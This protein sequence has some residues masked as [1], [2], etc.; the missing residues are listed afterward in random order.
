MRPREI[1]R[2][3]ALEDLIQIRIWGDKPGGIE[4]VEDHVDEFL[5]SLG[6]RPSLLPRVARLAE[7][8]ESE[9][10]LVGYLLRRVPEPFGDDELRDLPLRLFQTR[11]GA[12]RTPGR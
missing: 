7:L 1:L 8:Y 9:E 2:Q 11:H 6:L 5:D 10:E 12:G 3:L 4:H